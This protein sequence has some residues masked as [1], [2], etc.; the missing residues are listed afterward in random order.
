M[1]NFVQ[2]DKRNYSKRTPEEIKKALEE[3]L[4]RM[5]EKERI[6]SAVSR[7]EMQP[8]IEAKN[9]LLSE[10][11]KNSVLLGNTSLG[12]NYKIRLTAAKL[13]MLQARHNFVSYVSKNI[14]NLVNNINSQI[15]NLALKE[16]ITA[17]DV[18]IATSFEDEEYYRLQSEFS[19]AEK[20][21]DDV[22]AERDPKNTSANNQD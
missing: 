4:N 7:P 1:E 2:P 6:R 18:M 20:Y 21:Y 19:D 5:N 12:L 8:L 15:S 22:K 14:S 10:K 13:S 17:D 16:E 9:Q 11:N 3:K